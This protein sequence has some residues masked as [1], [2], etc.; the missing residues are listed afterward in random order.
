MA[1]R[2]KQ[3][4]GKKATRKTPKK[5][6]A[7][8][9]PANDAARI[10]AAIKRIP[11]GKV[12]TYGGVADVA[13]LPRRARLVGTV[14]RQTP[15]SRGVPWFRVINASGRISFPVG[16]DSY[17]RQRKHLENEG[18][19]FVGGRVSLERYG[20]PPREKMLDELVWGPA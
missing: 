16:S 19:D 1:S 8:L 14:L 13:G 6:T 7:V 4:A 17:A 11:R 3:K 12:C 15:A 2:N 9:A 20:W 10:I 18:I 5:K